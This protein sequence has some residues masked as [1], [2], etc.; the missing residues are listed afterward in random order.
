MCVLLV[1]AKW[2]VNNLRLWFLSVEVTCPF[3]RRAAAITAA[4]FLVVMVLRDNLWQWSINIL[5][6][7]TFDFDWDRHFLQSLYVFCV[8]CKNSAV[9]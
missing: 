1:H 8:L 3:Y 2:C 6:F 7:G 9:L 4:P 5:L